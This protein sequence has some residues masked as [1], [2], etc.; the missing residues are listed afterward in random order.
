MHGPPSQLAPSAAPR[1][2]GRWSACSARPTGA[3]TLR[4]TSSG[5]ASGG[6][7]CRGASSTSAA[8]APPRRK[9]RGSGATCRRCATRTGREPAPRWGSS[10]CVGCASTT[11]PQAMALQAL[12]QGC[13][14]LA[15]WDDDD[16]YG[17][18]YLE[19]MVA[20][21][22][23]ADLVKL[24]DFALLQVHG[25]G[26]PRLRSRGQPGGWQLVAS[27]S[28]NPLGYGWSL[29][30]RADALRRGARFP[31]SDWGEDNGFVRSAMRSGLRVRLVA[32]ACSAPAVHLD[33][34][35]GSSANV[36]RRPPRLKN[37]LPHLSLAALDAGAARRLGEY[38]DARVRALVAAH[39]L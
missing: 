15:H 18:D 1:A 39:G 4:D 5:R 29:V 11:T 12:S 13:D 26:T 27:G 7:P 34:G 16:V 37:H 17:A 24:R 3:G 33:L 23:D 20:L 31:Y 28:Q 9:S 10:A 21:L 30:Y 2:A 22:G 14:V 32:D 38:P 19:R 25:P 36:Q 8:T 35:A 6:R